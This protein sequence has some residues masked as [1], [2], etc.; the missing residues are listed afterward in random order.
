MKER[1]RDRNRER[2]GER[3]IEGEREGWDT[4]KYSA[5][6]AVVIYRLPLYIICCLQFFV[7]LR[8]FSGGG[9][10]MKHFAGFGDGFVVK[11]LFAPPFLS[12]C[13]MLTTYY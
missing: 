8:F 13:C 5:F 4:P 3:E 11:L 6:R 9:L 2:E 7:L 10:M 1:E 12:Y